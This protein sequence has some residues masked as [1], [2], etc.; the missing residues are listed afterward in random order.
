M[1]KRPGENARAG[2]SERTLPANAGTATLKAPKLRRQTFETA[3]RDRPRDSSSAGVV[4]PVP[5]FVRPHR[6]FRRGVVAVAGHEGLRGAPDVYFG[7]HGGSV[8]SGVQHGDGAD[9]P[10]GEYRTG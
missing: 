5:Q 1:H 8:V 2:R 3:S 4:A 7:E 10:D 6:R 9:E